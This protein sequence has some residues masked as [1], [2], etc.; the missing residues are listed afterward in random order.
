MTETAAC[1]TSKTGR[2][3]VV[4]LAKHEISVLENGAVVKTI[5]QFSTGRQGHLTP[6]INSGKID[7]GR[8]ERIHYSHT[9]KDSHGKPAA[10][11]FALFFNDGSGCAFHAGDANVESHGCIHLSSPDAEWLFN[12]SGKNDVGLQILGPNPHLAAK[13]QTV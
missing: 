7:P 11:P 12:W 5:T 8:R 1:N 9:Y 2:S 4:S 3:I 10:M 6:L 13:V